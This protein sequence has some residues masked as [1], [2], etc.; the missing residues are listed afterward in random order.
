MGVAAAFV[1]RIISRHRWVAWAG[2]VIVL[3]TALHMIWE[4]GQEVLHAMPH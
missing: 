4:G 1:A 3:Y 2:L